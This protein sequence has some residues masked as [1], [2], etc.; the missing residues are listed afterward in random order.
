MGNPDSGGSEFSNWDV[1]N[2]DC[3]V[4]L[5]GGGGVGNVVFAQTLL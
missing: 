4:F 3:F 5:G 2:P 1:E